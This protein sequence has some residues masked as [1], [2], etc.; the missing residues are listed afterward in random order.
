M[1]KIGWNA[2]IQNSTVQ[3]EAYCNE[4]EDRGDRDEEGRVQNKKK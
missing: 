4:G 2:T 3:K 1:G